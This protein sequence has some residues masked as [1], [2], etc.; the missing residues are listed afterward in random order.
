MKNKQEL[1]KTIRI[2]LI[3]GIC[4]AVLFSVLFFVQNRIGVRVT[5]EKVLAII[6][7]VKTRYPE[8][9]DADIY[10]ILKSDEA[11]SKGFADK[12]SFDIEK[13]ALIKEN[14]DLRRIFWIAAVSFF[15]LSMAVIA[16]IFLRYNAKKDKSIENITKLIAQINRKNY[17]LDLDGMSEDELSILKNE[18]YKTT[19]MLKEQA[20]NSLRDKVQLKDS[21]SDISHQL[22]TPL[23]AI[24]IR[25]DNLIDY[26]DMKA[27][28]KDAFVKDIKREVTNIHFFVQAI[29]KLSQIDANTV[30]YIKEPTPLHV[31]AQEA[32]QR[33]S[34]LCDLK[35]VTVSL[36]VRTEEAI[37]CDKL[38]QVE[39]IGNILK[40]CIEHSREGGTVDITVDSNTA[41]SSIVIRDY[42]DGISPA[43]LHHLFDRFYRGENA[44]EGSIG[45]GLALAKSIITQNGGTVSVSSQVGEGTCF[46]IK[47]L[48]FE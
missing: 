30:S 3:T 45:I 7:E 40:N 15:V 39:A 26:P 14:D 9:T 37:I 5:N 32:M 18:I 42:G 44:G 13:D 23:S 22:K 46:A 10:A 17:K 16:T 12:Y 4:L 2:V 21:L 1:K 28:Q 11:V 25:L 8:M 24:M 43:D 29:L 20:E 36:D 41:Y 34:A 19:I 47:Y 38:W 27:E 35:N 33:L 6:E 31:L 48:K